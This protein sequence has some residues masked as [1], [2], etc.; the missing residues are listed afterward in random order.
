M[1]F[2][3]N[4]KKAFQLLSKKLLQVAQLKLSI[5]QMKNMIQIY[6]YKLKNLQLAYDIVKVHKRYHFYLKNFQEF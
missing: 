5:S 4:L 3:L 6:Y 2:F 1:I